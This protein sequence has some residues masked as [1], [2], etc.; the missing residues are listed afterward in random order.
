MTFL[1]ERQ[2]IRNVTECENESF[3]WDRRCRRCEIPKRSRHLPNWWSQCEEMVPIKEKAPRREEKVGGWSAA[4]GRW[5]H[6][7]RGTELGGSCF[8]PSSTVKGVLGTP[9]RMSMFPV[10]KGLGELTLLHTWGGA[11]PMVP[12]PQLY[13][14]F[15]WTRCGGRASCS[16]LG[17]GEA[18]GKHGAPGGGRRHFERPPGARQ[19]TVRCRSVT[20][21]PQVTPVT[22]KVGFTP[23]R[24]GSEN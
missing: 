4:E 8:P 16:D 23:T 13:R 10:A 5:P 21:S 15:P 24:A 1:W 3:D 14:C 7:D 18:G 22:T 6:W 17:K 9:G 12:E 19:A 2:V 20:Q 11:T